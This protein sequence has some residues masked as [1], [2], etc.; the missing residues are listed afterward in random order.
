MSYASQFDLENVYGVE[1]VKRLSDHDN[2]GVA[3]NNAIEDA[4]TGASAIIDGYLAVKY[5]V[6]LATPTPIVRNLCLDI[7]WYRLGYARQKWTIEMRQRYEDAIDFLKMVAAGK[8][9][10]GLDTDADGLS[11]DQSSTLVSS[12]GFL[13]RA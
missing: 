2:D 7:A 3:D 5:Q 1:Q 4:L 6:P 13:T 11:D 12:T 9:A 10:I 8:A